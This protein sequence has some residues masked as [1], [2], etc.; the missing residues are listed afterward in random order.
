MTKACLAVGFLLVIASGAL[1]STSTCPD[2]TQGE[3][4]Q[5]CPW[6]A[7]SRDLT[8]AGTTDLKALGKLLKER[9][10]AL[11]KEIE[12]ERSS[13]AWHPLWGGSINFDELAHGQ[14]V[15]P[16]ILRLLESLFGY[17]EGFALPGAPANVFPAGLEHTYGYL[18]SVLKTSFGFKRSRWVAGEINRGFA[19]SSNPIS[20]VPKHGSLFRNVTYF[21]GRIA[22]R[23]EP[24]ALEA[25]EAGKGSVDPELVSLQYDKLKT[26]RLEEKLTLDAGRSVVI[27]TDLVTF[28]VA[29]PLANP[30]PNDTLLVYSYLDND[31]PKLVTAFPVTGAFGAGIMQPS[32]LG[33]NQPI[34]SRYNAWIAGVSDRTDLKGTRAVAP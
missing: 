14:I 18:F 24:K 6:A 9:S 4:A 25:L 17:P 22:F 32:T 26:V 19:F 27:R 7:I 30:A 1:A 2:T 16:S 15:D 5:D 31:V 8:A 12:S 21:A 33:D 23:S 29:P 3:T 28:P 34:I 13:T 11:Y 20:P 10:K